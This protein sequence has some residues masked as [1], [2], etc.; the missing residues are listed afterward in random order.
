M[1][2]NHPTQGLPQLQNQGFVPTPQGS[3]AG[4]PCQTDDELDELP[5]VESV[6]PKHSRGKPGRT[7]GR[8]GRTEEIKGKYKSL[9]K[10]KLG[11][12]L[13]GDLSICKILFVE[14]LQNYGVS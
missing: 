7:T 5:D 9:L 2:L 14:S 11:P 4:T 10:L 12:I 8:P 3:H 1:V 13:S 6:D